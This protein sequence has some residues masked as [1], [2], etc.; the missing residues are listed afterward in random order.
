M[1][2]DVCGRYTDDLGGFQALLNLFIGYDSATDTVTA[3][4][5]LK[6]SG[7]FFALRAGFVSVFRGTELIFLPF[8]GY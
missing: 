8:I 3:G 7:L 5:R 2:I 4:L 1:S 6:L